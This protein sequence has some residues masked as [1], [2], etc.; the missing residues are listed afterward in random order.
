MTDIQAPC[1]KGK[2]KDY[3]LIVTFS[4]R[5][6]TKCQLDMSENNYAWQCNCSYVHKVFEVFNFSWH[7]VWT[8]H[9]KETSFI[10]KKNKHTDIFWILFIERSDIEYS[11]WCS[12]RWLYHWSNSLLNVKE[13]LDGIYF[14]FTNGSSAI[15]WIIWRKRF[16]KACVEVGTDA[17]L[18]V[19]GI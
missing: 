2:Y 15:W 16:S 17:L 4:T 19:K 8:V 10:K 3:F 1:F 14:Q 12:Q 13:I 9:W 6:C 7:L 11:M 18:K 5:A